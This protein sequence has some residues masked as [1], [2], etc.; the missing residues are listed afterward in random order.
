MQCDDMWLGVTLHSTATRIRWCSFL[1]SLIGRVNE[2][3]PLKP[4]NIGSEPKKELEHKGICHFFE[5]RSPDLTVRPRGRLFRRSSAAEEHFAI[6]PARRKTATQQKTPP[7]ANQNQSTGQTQEKMK[8]GVRHHNLDIATLE[9]GLSTTKGL[10]P[11]DE[12]SVIMAGCLLIA[13]YGFFRS[14]PV[15]RTS[16]RLTLAPACGD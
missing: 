16:R 12:G 6:V 13:A 4:K 15:E 1:D 10:E 14:F 5:S 11:R 2:T 9:N 8:H 7:S 3:L